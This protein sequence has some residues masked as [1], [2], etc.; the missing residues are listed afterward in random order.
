MTTVKRRLRWQRGAIAVLLALTAAACGSTV[1]QTGSRGAAGGS[2]Q[3]G[4]EGGL[5]A[6]SV[7]GGATSGDQSAGGIASG[8]ATGGGSSAT[9]RRSGSTNSASASAGSGIAGTGAAGNG[10]G[11]DA[12]TVNVGIAYAVNS[13]AAN[14]AIGANG[15]TQGDTKAE[16]QALIDDINA[17]GGFAGRKVVPVWHEYD[18]KSTAS[19]DAQEQAACDDYTQDHET[20]AVMD[21]A[22]DP[23]LAC[24]DKRGGLV[25]DSPLSASD[26]AR[27]TRF[28]YY[29][30][31]A[32]MNLDR[33]AAAL[34]PA[35]GTQGWSAGWDASL[36]QPRSQKAKVG[37]VAYDYPT[38][39]HA[40]DQ[41][42]VPGLAKV[43]LAPDAADVR[44][45][46]WLQSNSDAGAVA[47]AI[48]SAVL[49]FRQ[50]GVDHVIVFDERGLLTLLFL[51]TAQSQHYFPRYGWTSQNGPQTFLDAGDVQPQQ[52]VGSMGIGWLPQLDIT[53]SQNL[54]NGPYSN[55]A[56][57]RCVAL[58][59]SKG[60][61]FP[62]TNAE[63]GG[64][65]ICTQFWFFQAV[66][67]ALGTGPINRGRFMA[68]V[69]R[70]GS[71]FQGAGSLGLRF[72]PGQHDGIAVYRHYAYDAGCSCMQ[73]KSGNIPAP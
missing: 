12:K 39:A 17:H 8:T 30:E 55:D 35:L 9:A 57:R 73:Y 52:L 37:I 63:A 33:S 43:G 34:A 13:S 29:V 45:V 44:R 26:G 6:G 36:G 71:S 19:A 48:S 27:F 4:G 65:D 53:P 21:S 61:S 3:G 42:L 62:D 23:L 32:S 16:E 7:P 68:A 54:D 25:V 51:K 10:P 58:Y 2:Q 70:L 22:R 46:T 14:A 69:E 38:F 1:Q 31:V 11:V 18:A 72:G 5:D 15:V 20:F 40:V 56:R 66:G 50:D 28:P 49:K 67:N 41:V 24:L 60:I 47:A 59:R 64:L